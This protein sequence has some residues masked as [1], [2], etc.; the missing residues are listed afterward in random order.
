MIWTN[1]FLLYLRM[2]SQKLKIFWIHGFWEEDFYSC[3]KL[4][5]STNQTRFSEM[6]T[7]FFPDGKSERKFWYVIFFQTNLYINYCLFMFLG[8]YSD[9]Y[10]GIC[11]WQHGVIIIGLI[12][13]YP[14][15]TR[16]S[17]GVAMT[18]N[19]VKLYRQ[20]NSIG[21]FLFWKFYNVHQGL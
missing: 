20:K 5:P 8:L 21:L 6:I 15:W 7:I 14:K 3:L 1:L 12:L 11:K 4:D 9:K 2:L 17:L 19:S 10:Y 16:Q 18:P 13:K